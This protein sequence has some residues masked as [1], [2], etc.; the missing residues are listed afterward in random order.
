MTDE[1]ILVVFAKN[2]RMLVARNDNISFRSLGKMI[3]INYGSLHEYA[4]AE[5]NIPLESA[6]RIARYFG[7]TVDEMT[8]PMEGSD[9]YDIKN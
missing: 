2:L 3:G 4:Q 5:S 6:R 8:E 1:D 9:A 7:K